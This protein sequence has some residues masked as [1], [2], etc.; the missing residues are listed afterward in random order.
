MATNGHADDALAALDRTVRDAL[1]YFEA[2]G[3]TPK[4]SAGAWGA[5]E[6]LCHLLFWHEVTIEGMNSG[7][8]GDGPYRLDRAADELNARAIAEHQG[9]SFMELTAGL[10]SLQEQ[11]QRAARSLPDLDAPVMMRVDGT[12]LSGRQRLEMIA[13]HWSQHLAEL[14][15]AEQ[16]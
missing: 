5:W 6:V 11:L 14:K 4:A 3:P 10:L 12:L 13:R 1:A 9:T 16:S 7:A 15:A 2:M 8:R